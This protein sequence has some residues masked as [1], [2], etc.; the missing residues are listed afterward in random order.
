M[1]GDPLEVTTVIAAVVFAVRAHG[2]RG[3]RLAVVGA[4]CYVLAL[5][6]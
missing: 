1:V 4:V 2:L 6:W 5:G 3:G